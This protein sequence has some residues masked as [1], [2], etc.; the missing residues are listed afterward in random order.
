[1]RP[2]LPDLLQPLSLKDRYRLWQRTRSQKAFL[3]S[4]APCAGE[5]HTGTGLRVLVL[6][7]YLTDHPNHAEHLVARYSASQRHAVDQVWGAVGATP[8]P[9]CLHHVTRVHATEKVPKFILLNQ[10]LEG[11]RIS[12]YDYLI[13][14][15]DDITVQANFLDAYLSWVQA[16][17]F[18]IAQP[19]RTRHSYR[20]HRFVLQQRFMK[21]RETRFV[22]IGPVF[23]F[24]RAAAECL[25]PFD[26]SSPM[27]WGYDYVWPVVA[28]RLGWS[29]GIIDIVPVDHS[30]RPQSKTYDTAQTAGVMRNYLSCH[31]H[32]TPERA[33]TTLRNHRCP[34]RQRSA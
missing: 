17:H 25:L 28:E 30:Y 26:A 19:A 20:A 11:I 16:Y 23:S 1:M 33:F 3:D 13:F 27:G 10:L 5:G 14:S 22:E 32:L 6:G 2:T 21:G 34:P 29:M 31:S 12:D 7:I 24:D 18:S 9:A 15:D 4:L 8:P